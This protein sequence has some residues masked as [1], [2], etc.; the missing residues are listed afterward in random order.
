MLGDAE[1][2]Q[3]Y[4]GRRME[5]VTMGACLAVDGVSRDGADAWDA[6]QIREGGWEM[7][8]AEGW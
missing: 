2:R 5:A 8:I 4:Q 6:W 7:Q 1:R 3:G